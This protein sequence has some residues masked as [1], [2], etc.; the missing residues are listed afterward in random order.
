M[1]D[2]TDMAVEERVEEPS[3]T[4]RV[5]R[6]E[7]VT[8]GMA[9]VV[10]DDLRPEP[11]GGPAFASTGVG[12]EVVRLLLPSGS[13][14]VDV[15]G[16]GDGAVGR[17]YTVRRWD[18]RRGELWVD[19]VRHGHGPA[20]RWAESAQPGDRV[21]LDEPDGRFAAPPEAAWVALVGDAT[22]LPAVARLVE[23]AAAG[24]VDLP[25][26]RVVV[27][28]DDARDHQA[29]PLRDGDEL[30]WLGAGEDLLAAVVALCDGA[31]EEGGGPGYLWFAGE[32]SV[33]RAVRRHV[34]HER[35]WPTSRWT[36]MAYWR[37]DTRR[38]ERALAADGGWLATELE[39]I[40]SADGDGE[41]LRDRAD[42]LLT[43]H[44]L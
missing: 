1:A 27:Q 14:D 36:T 9:R 33:M 37:R 24:L 11:A 23:D 41:E 2:V 34:R 30:R 16:G 21:V 25:P 39:Q 42:A 26:L 10:L 12:D 35:G 18:P 29:L 40:W 17:Y 7:L 44:G 20:A 43:R 3:W 19:L 15:D 22:A 5:A 6:R 38:W 8:P 13:G 32:A 28:V 31:D 4:A